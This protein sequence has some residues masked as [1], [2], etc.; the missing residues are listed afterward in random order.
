M[1]A[2]ARELIDEAHAAPY[3][4]R[5]ASNICFDILRHQTVWRRIAPEYVANATRA[6][7]VES[8]HLQRDFARELMS[9][10]GPLT[11][12]VGLMHLVEG[13]SQR[14]IADEVGISRRSIFNHLKKLERHVLEMD[15]EAA[16]ATP[17]ARRSA[18]RQARADGPDTRFARREARGPAHARSE[19]AHLDLAR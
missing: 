9:R 4:F 3:L 1:R 7:R 5:T 11:V 12:T 6:D 17:S 19:D 2:Y 15:G 13:M 10:L 14:E 16:R 8:Q 18:A